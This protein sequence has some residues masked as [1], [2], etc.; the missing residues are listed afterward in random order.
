MNLVAL[1]LVILL[2]TEHWLPLGPE[3]GLVRNLIFCA[4]LIFGLLGIRKVFT[5]YYR[6]A[7]TWMLDH[8]AQFL[9]V[10]ITLVLLGVLIWLG[11][12]RVFGFIPD[13]A[14]RIFGW[15]PPAPTK[16][17]EEMPEASKPA[18]S[19]PGMSHGTDMGAKPMSA[20]PKDP[21]RASRVWQKLSGL[22][23]GLGKEFMPDL[24]E[25]TFLYMPT[26]MP[27]A[28]IGQALDVIHTQNLAIKAIPEVQSAVG[29]IG[30]VESAL[31]PAPISMIETIVNFIPEYKTDPESGHHVLDPKTGK[32]IRQWRQE[33]QSVNDIWN[34]IVKAAHLP[35]TTVAPRLQPIA[36]RVVMLQTGMRSAMGIKVRGN[37]LEEL[38]QVGLQMERILREVPSIEPSSVIADRNIGVPYL[39]IDIDREAIARYGVNVQDVNDV[40]EIA[41]GGRR[42]TTTVEGRERYPVRVRYDR[43]L[44]DSV[45]AL[46]DIL[47]PGAKGVHIPMKSLATINYVRGPMVIKSENTF[48]VSYVLFDK[49]PGIAEVTAVEDADKYLREKIS[50]GE[51]K[52]PENTSYIFTGSYENQVRSEKTMMIV[53][54]ITLLLVFMI[55]YFQFQSVPTSLNVFSGIFVA[56]SG[57]FLLIWLYSQPWFLDFNV[58]GVHMRHLFQVR[59]YNLSVA[60]WVG[61]LALFG[62]A[63]ND[64]VIY[65]TYLN[66]VFARHKFK[67]IKEIR[68]ATVEAG[69][70]RIR[71][72][73]M[74]SACA[75][76]ALIPVLTSQGRGADVMVPMA[77]PIVG[78]MFLDLIT[79]FVVPTLYCLE[80]EIE[81]KRRIQSSG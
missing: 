9:I 65:S 5:G 50:A 66:Q 79:V 15:T 35:G 68:E 48:L 72:A 39:E 28:S 60:V 2:L 78:G 55:L 20:P 10:P 11:F 30:R 3:R 58:F 70:K 42:I 77:L 69:I 43:E 33:I 29:K 40:I 46:D 21:I 16:Q 44:R 73:L 56:W 23:P 52:L 26:L 6:H 63:T 31:D 41:I 62:I 61:F 19:M 12:D 36:G 59:P 57:G 4:G 51:L 24:E 54:P 53:I 17:M 13:T 34:E 47:V 75:I 64:G 74:T 71:P 32:P 14:T 38:E 67:S 18:T 81:F 22:F 45:E 37:S 27:H 7:L 76:L 49:K 8:K 25:G 1:A 80:K